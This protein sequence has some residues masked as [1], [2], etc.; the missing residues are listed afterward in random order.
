[1]KSLDKIKYAFGTCTFDIKADEVT[2]CVNTQGY[3]HGR[4]SIA[5][6]NTQTQCVCSLSAPRNS[7][8]TIKYDKNN[9][10]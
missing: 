9:L 2:W 8:L 4:R 10:R 6:R 1:M 7:Q 5:T 3:T